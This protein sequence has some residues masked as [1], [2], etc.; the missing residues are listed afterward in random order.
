MKEKILE[1]FSK[2]VEKVK[3][4]IPKS[5]AQDSMMIVMAYGLLIVIIALA[6]MCAWL[7]EGF[8]TGKFDTDIMLRF[9]SAATAPGPVAAVTFLSVFLVDKNKDGRPDAA[10]NRADTSSDRPMVLR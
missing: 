8:S 3:S 7:H 2:V 9:F 1:Y 6:F 4:Y 5:N 10:E